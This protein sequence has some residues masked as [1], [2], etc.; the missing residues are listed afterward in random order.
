MLQN[1]ETKNL[2]YNL[3]PFIRFYFWLERYYA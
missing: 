1:F 2:N 3:G